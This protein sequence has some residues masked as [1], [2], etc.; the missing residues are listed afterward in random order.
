MEDMNSVLYLGRRQVHF[1]IGENKF[2]AP[3]TT[4]YPNI[5]DFGN[6]TDPE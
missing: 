5:Y 4:H 3:I 6:E 1:T 2:N